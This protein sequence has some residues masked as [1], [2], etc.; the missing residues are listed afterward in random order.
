[1]V[2]P[3]GQNGTLEN[4]V[5]GIP[6]DPSSVQ[7]S[8]LTLRGIQL[9]YKTPYV[10]S[11]NLTLQ[12][13]LSP[14]TSLEAGYVASLSRHLEA[15]VGTNNASVL[16]PPGTSITPYIPFP[17]FSP[18]SPYDD[19]IGTADYHSLQTKLERRFAKG[20]TMLVAY[21]FS[22][23]LT[24]AGDLLSGGGVGGF[25]APDLPGFGIQGDWALA[26]FDIRHSFSASG[27]YDL[28]FG[29]GRTY[30]TSGSKL[31]E[32]LFGGWSFNWI[33]SLHSGNPQT[34]PC[35]IGT[36]ANNGCD[37]LYTGASLYSGQS[38]SHFYNAA[39]FM[40][41]PVV[42]QIGQTNYAPLG[43]A[44]TQV[45]GPAFHRLDF[46]LFKAFPITRAK[47]VRTS[48]G[49]LQSDQHSEFRA[50]KQLEFPGHRGLRQDHVD[51]R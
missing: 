32:G 16:L 15:F 40:N 43:G 6:L 20:L 13:Q 18:G 10:Q 19:T 24:D 7:G 9:H 51:C 29:R 47:A 11:Y 1:M 50:A 26:P 5:A 14:S 39:A 42:T 12:Y 21:T 34:I 8:G 31:A 4:S 35:T 41:P 37:A 33:L 17:D 38:V 3:N 23:T 46:S 30:M 48:R 22:K 25:R 28:P 44:N 27:S 36:G 49:G 45:S 2:L